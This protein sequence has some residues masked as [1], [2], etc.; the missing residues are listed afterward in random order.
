MDSRRSAN[1]SAA[2]RAGGG[3]E[4]SR[5]ADA[6]AAPAGAS[7]VPRPSGRAAAAGDAALLVCAVLWGTTFP[8]TKLAMAHS[9]PLAFTAFRFC[10]ATVALVPLAL[11]GPGLAGLWRARWWGCGVG[12]LVAAGFWLQTYG[13][14]RI[15]SPRSAFLTAFYV[16]FTLGLEWLVFRRPPGWWVAAGAALAF[17]GVA[18]MTGAGAGDPINSGDVATLVCALTFAGQMVLLSGALKRH[19][20]GQILFLE[21]GSC[22]VL[23]IVAAPLFET[24]RLDWSAPLVATAL[25]LA[26]IA[27]ALVLGLQ[28]FGQKR[29]TASRAGVLFSSEPVWTTVFAAAF[30]GEVV[31]GRTLVGGALVLGGL[32]VTTLAPRPAPH[33]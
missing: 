1:A 3:R 25:Y 12:L 19:D 6:P 8:L 11:R 33:A 26:L 24:P 18:V 4:A 30:F 10:L 7:R 29:T 32:L 17:V 2:P 13:L 27:T 21:I 14:T 20:P 23:S 31:T 15:S 28:N 5:S 9:T 16:F 22:A